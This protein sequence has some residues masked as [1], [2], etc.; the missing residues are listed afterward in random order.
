MTT[1][2]NSLITDLKK[3]ID[4]ITTTRILLSRFDNGKTKELTQQSYVTFCNLVV[5]QK[6]NQTTRFNTTPEQLKVQQELFNTSV[7]AHKKKVIERSIALANDFIEFSSEY[8]DKIHN[9][10]MALELSY[11][12]NN[13]VQLPNNKLNILQLHNVSPA[14]QLSQRLLT[15]QLIT[16]Q[17]TDVKSLLHEPVLGDEP[18]TTLTEIQKL[19]KNEKSLQIINEFYTSSV[20]PYLGVEHC[21]VQVANASAKDSNYNS[22]R[23]A[24]LFSTILKLTSDVDKLQYHWGFEKP[25]YSNDQVRLVQSLSQL[26]EIAY[27]TDTVNHATAMTVRLN[28]LYKAMDLV[29]HVVYPCLLIELV[30]LEQV[31][32]ELGQHKYLDSDATAIESKSYQLEQQFDHDQ[33]YLTFLQNKIST[34]TISYVNESISY[35]YDRLNKTIQTSNTAKKLMNKVTDTPLPISEKMQVYPVEVMQTYLDGWKTK[36]QQWYEYFQSVMAIPTTL[37]SWSSMVMITPQWDT[38]IRDDCNRLH[39]TKLNQPTDLTNPCKYQSV[40]RIGR[41]ALIP[42]L[43]ESLGYQQLETQTKLKESVNQLDDQMIKLQLQLH[44]FK[45]TIASFKSS[46]NDRENLSRCY[47]IVNSLLQQLTYTSHDLDILSSAYV[48]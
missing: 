28:R 22:M 33:A 20:S 11:R 9:A 35:C 13:I 37:N 5:T 24:E 40:Y 6:E 12:I 23:C 43:T 45:T 25:R 41:E 46:N 21:R 38:L 44:A 2:A 17:L 34:P 19:L 30:G 14:K 4:P 39:L 42:I 1:T 3:S 8:S 29:T 26:S 36:Y 32:S 47:T 27:S 10:K 18:G 7:H 16:N 15:L 48:G 31:Y